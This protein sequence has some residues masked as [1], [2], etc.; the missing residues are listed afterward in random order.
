MRIFLT[1]CFLTALFPFLTAQNILTPGQLI[2]FKDGA[3]VRQKGIVRFIEKVARIDPQ[4]DLIPESIEVN[5]SNE[6]EIN[7]VRFLMDTVKETRQVSD[8]RDVIRANRKATITVVYEIGQEFDEVAG[9]V[10]MIDEVAGIFVLRNSKDNDIFIPFDQVRQVMTDTIASYQVTHTVLR[11]SL[12]VK[13]NQDIPFAPIEIS[14]LM[15]GFTWDA[16]CKLRLVDE[17]FAMYDMTALVSNEAG[18][19]TDVEVQLS[20]NSILDEIDSQNQNAEMFRA[21]KATFR[22]GERMILK[23]AS[24]KHEYQQQYNSSI[25]WN[26]VESARRNEPFPVLHSLK[27]TNPA[28]PSVACTEL[29]VYN[30]T[31]QLISM[32]K[33]ESPGAELSL[34]DLGMESRIKVYCEETEMKRFPKPVKIGEKNYNKMD[35]S[36][37]VT[38]VNQYPEIVSIRIN[39]SLFGEMTDIGGARWEQST[40]NPLEHTLYWIA[41]L[42][43]AQS[44]VFEYQYQ[45][46]IPQEE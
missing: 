29:A 34:I 26:G 45:A 31:R 27:L 25:P 46:L 12:E 32:G 15:R 35:I 13:M 14:G 30:E 42:K 28:S 44:K 6:F 39:R 37:K 9:E 4:Y 43:T 18:D 16:T 1:V 5:H 7:Y 23:L 40:T 21:G 10:R 24:T 22:K 41:N 3:Q 33:L 11:P 38:V 2:I 8:W 36:G 19:F 17:K 20:G